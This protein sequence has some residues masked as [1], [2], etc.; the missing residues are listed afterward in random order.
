MTDI[1]IN[2]AAGR[3]GRLLVAEACEDERF[4]IVAARE[5]PGS[6]FIGEDCGE[7]AGIGEIGVAIAGGLTGAEVVI[8][9]STAEGA[10]DALEYCLEAE[11]A[12]VTGTT[13][14]EEEHYDRLYSA[15]KQ[16]G[17]LAASNFSLGVAALREVAAELAGRFPD[18][19]IE[20]IEAHHNRKADSPSGT[21]LSIADSIS[22]VRMLEPVFGRRGRVGPR[23]NTELGIHSV[24]AGGIIGEHRIIFG[25]PHETIILKHRAVSRKLFAWGALEAGAAISGKTGY[26]EIQD[27]FKKNTGE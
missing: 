17:V 10:M 23:D 7:V 18:A 5:H 14:L 21:A 16:I 4:R 9:F 22:E 8:D 1:G 26:F 24:R 20:I 13:A 3:M 25:M 11:A 2:G 27:L 19:D 15:G 12:L 6:E